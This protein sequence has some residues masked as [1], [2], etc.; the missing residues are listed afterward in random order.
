MA[1]GVRDGAG[2]VG[3]ASGGGSGGGSGSVRDGLGA[4]PERAAGAGA[5]GVGVDGAGIVA[6]SPRAQRTSRSS[7]LSTETGATHMVSRATNGA[8]MMVDARGNPQQA[9]KMLCPRATPVA[10]PFWGSGPCSEACPTPRKRDGHGKSRLGN[11]T[12]AATSATA[13]S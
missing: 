13:G 11:Q 6:R 2:V 9:M 4:R 8:P 7:A 3:S 12:T 1:V 5:F 10:L